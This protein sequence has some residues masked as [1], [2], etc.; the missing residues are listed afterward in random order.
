MGFGEGLA[1]SAASLDDQHLVGLQTRQREPSPAPGTFDG[2]G[3]AERDGLHAADMFMPGLAS[4]MRM[5]RISTG[6][7]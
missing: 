7:K 6:G 5:S 4:S 2:Q 3:A 1:L